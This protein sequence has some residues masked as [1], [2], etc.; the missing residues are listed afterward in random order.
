MKPIYLNLAA[1]LIFTVSCSTFADILID[2]DNQAEIDISNTQQLPRYTL[3]ILEPAFQKAIM[4]SS[5]NDDKS[6][7]INKLPYHDEVMLAAKETALEPALIH[8]IITVESKHNAVATS[9]KGAYGLM[10][11]MP[12]TAS[13]FKVINKYDPQQNILAGAKYMRELLTKYDGNLN[14]SLAAY[15]AGPTAIRKYGGKIPPYC[16]TLIYVPKVLKY[17]HQYS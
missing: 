2:L 11:L 8:A 3:I 10:Q 15:N 13:R 6:I 5:S 14:L 12:E 16:E 9:K 7:K 1:I 4:Q 17:Y